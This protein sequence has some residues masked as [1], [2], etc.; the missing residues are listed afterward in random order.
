MEKPACFNHGQTHTR[1][2]V[3]VEKKKRAREPDGGLG[4]NNEVIKFNKCPFSKT[5][6]E[7]NKWN[8]AQILLVASHLLWLCICPCETSLWV[9]LDWR[10]NESHFKI[11]S[12]HQKYVAIYMCVCVC[13][14]N[15]IF[16]E[17]NKNNRLQVIFIL[18]CRW[19]HCLTKKTP[20]RRPGTVILSHTC[21]LNVFRPYFFFTQRRFN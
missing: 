1:V 6:F 12:R 7:N 13:I 10:D 18:A 9:K 14:L 17:T 4:V 19:R 3:R 15:R 16:K 20:I 5:D 8:A 11:H 2:C 21:C